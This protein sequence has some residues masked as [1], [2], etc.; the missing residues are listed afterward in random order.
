[1]LPDAERA[2]GV[3]APGQRRPELALLP[4][5]ARI[6]LIGG[7]DTLAALLAR[8]AQYRLTEPQPLRGVRFL[9]HRV[10]AFRAQAHR[11]D[12]VRKPGGLAPCGCQRD[13]QSDL[14]AI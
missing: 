5:L 9:A 11:Q 7:V 13:V 2:V 6:G 10:V 3:D 12:V 1:M 14:V 4:Y 8:D